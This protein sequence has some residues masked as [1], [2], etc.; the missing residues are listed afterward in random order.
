MSSDK[1]DN[2]ITGGDDSTPGV[3]EIKGRIGVLVGDGCD[4]LF[5]S[6]EKFQRVCLRRCGG[7]QLLQ[8]KMFHILTV[9]GGGEQRGNIFM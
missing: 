7:R 3:V 2:L 9:V 5:L 8:Y 6:G 4:E 1:T